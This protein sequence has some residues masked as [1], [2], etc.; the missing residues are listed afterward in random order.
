[1]TSLGRGTLYLIVGPSGAGKDSLVDAVRARFGA[2][3]AFPQRLITRPAGKNE[4]HIEVDD[5]TFATREKAGEF[6]LSW[7]AHGLSYGIPRTIETA[8]KDGTSVVIN[9]S[10]E[11]VGIARQR[12]S[13][14]RVI[15][16]TAPKHILAARLQARGRE[17]PGDVENRLERRVD[18]VP[19]VIIVN[20]GAIDAAVQAFA[21]AL[22]G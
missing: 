11:V 2:T 3:H 21:T 8:L 18:V 13:P 20:D 17:L 12:L 6:I 10:R 7:Q 14:V 19:D 1:M 4:D 16:V 22:G 9:V 15:L 5:E